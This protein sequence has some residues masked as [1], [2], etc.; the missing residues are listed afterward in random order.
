M[1]PSQREKPL[2]VVMPVHNALPYLDAAVRSILEQSFTDFEF[3][4]FDD[5][6]TDGSTERL[7]EWAA[8][9]DRIRLEISDRNLGPVASSNRIVELAGSDLIARMDADDISQPDRLER[10]VRLL[11]DRPDLGLVGT[12]FDVIDAAGRRLRRPNLWRLTHASWHAPFTH[13][14]IMFRRALF[15]KIGGYREQCVFWEDHDLY[16]RAA[17]VTT[18]ATVPLSLYLHRQSQVSTRLVSDQ[19]QV[20]RSID[21]VFRCMERLKNGESYEDLLRVPEA[22]RGSRVDPRVFVSLGSIVLWAGGRPRFLGRLLSRG[23]L[24]FSFAS[25]SAL[26]WSF[27]ASL[28]PSSLRGFLRLLA[29]TRNA[30]SRRDRLERDAIRWRTPRQLP[31]LEAHPVQSRPSIASAPAKR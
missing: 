26:A 14:S 5:G 31:P 6:S 11:L 28:S 21:L 22:P 4:I 1:P 12:L 17:R 25:L 20:E 16:W 3:V 13:G 9:D 27:W 19:E 7:L 24:D 2:S 8:R 30:L 23:R 18:I 15:E 29:A 10:Q